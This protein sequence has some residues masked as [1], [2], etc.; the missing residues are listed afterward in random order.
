[1]KKKLSVM[2][3]KAMEM[4]K[5]TIW[6]A[7]EIYLFIYTITWEGYT[8]SS[9]SQACLYRRN[10]NIEHKNNKWQNVEYVQACT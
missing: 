3:R 2:W 1:M 10:K 7:R 6:N 5:G 9:D 8:F 4:E